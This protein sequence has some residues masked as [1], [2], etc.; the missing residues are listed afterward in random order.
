M[1]HIS[2]HTHQCA[3]RTAEGLSELKHW[4]GAPVCHL[5]G[6]WVDSGKEGSR[7]VNERQGSVISFNVKR[8]TGAW[9]GYAEVGQAARLEG[10]HLRTGLFCNP[11]AGER[12]L[13]ID[14]DVV[15]ANLK[16]GHV[17]WDALD[18][19]D[20]KPTGAIRVS[21]GYM[22]S[23]SDA[24]AVIKL[25]SDYFIETKTEEKQEEN[26]ANEDGVKDDVYLKEIWVY[27]VKSLGGM[28]VTEWETTQDK[29]LKYDREWAIVDSDGVS[30]TQKTT[31]NMANISARV[32]CKEGEGDILELTAAGFEPFRL[33][34][35]VKGEISASCD[36]PT[37]VR[38]CGDRCQAI[39]YP[40]TKG[41][42]SRVLG[43]NCELIRQRAT[44]VTTT[45]VTERGG[46]G[47]M[48]EGHYLLISEASVSALALCVQAD[49]VEKPRDFNFRA[50]ILIGGPSLEAYAEDGW[51]QVKIGDVDF[52]VT[53]PCTRCMVV[54]V[55]KGEGVYKREPLRTLVKHRRFDGKV[56]F[57]VHLGS[58]PGDTGCGAGKIRVG[59]VIQRR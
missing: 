12:Y 48:N 20:G 38:V 24:E 52:S 31:P 44:N 22:S 54:N 40:E 46:K 23:M 43:T 42:L 14:A 29:G 11:G 21:F 17:C 9:V 51:K 33:Y 58:C 55:E 5:F 18:L 50:N 32:V 19:I 1:E 27:P 57:G 3:L 37:E 34:L 6:A 53:A 8:A 2:A 47:F 26:R 4:N 15:E 30:L 25:I 45:T 13:G 16:R 49:G 56:L 28:R 10:L 39:S 36:T 7:D 41:W 59:D 35:G